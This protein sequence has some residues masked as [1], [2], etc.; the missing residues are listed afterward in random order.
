MHK[1]NEVRVNHTRCDRCSAPA[2][3]VQPDGKTLCPNC[4]ATPKTASADEGS[5]KSAA[6]TLADRFK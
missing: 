1:T 4:L 2:A 5:L 3:V 6:D